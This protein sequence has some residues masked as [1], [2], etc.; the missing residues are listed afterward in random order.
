MTLNITRSM[1]CE[2]IWTI[3]I[4]MLLILLYY[5]FTVLPFF[6]PLG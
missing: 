1:T 2:A 3:L 6:L 5:L 4:I